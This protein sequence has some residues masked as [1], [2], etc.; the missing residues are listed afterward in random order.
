MK[1]KFSESK[2]PPEM[3]ETLLL[4]L[5]FISFRIC[6]EFDRRAYGREKMDNSE[7]RDKYVIHKIW[8]LTKKWY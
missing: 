2:S 1:K 4:S 3:N 6:K 8:F 5:I 7:M